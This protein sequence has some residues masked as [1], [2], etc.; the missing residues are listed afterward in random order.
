MISAAVGRRSK[1]FDDPVDRTC[2]VEVRDDD[3]R[4]RGPRTNRRLERRAYA[5]DATL[6]QREKRGLTR[7]IDV[8]E[9]VLDV[10]PRSA[11]I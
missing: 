5:F 4:A 3:V 1:R 8:C 7:R 11:R 10:T 2:A 9:V 6:Y